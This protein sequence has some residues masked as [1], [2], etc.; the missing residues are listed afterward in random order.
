[1]LLP[2]T[3]SVPAITLWCVSLAWSGA[4]LGVGGIWNP[5]SRSA[6]IRWRGFHLGL[7]FEL[8]AAAVVLL[9]GVLLMATWQLHVK[10]NRTPKH[11]CIGC[12]YKEVR[13]V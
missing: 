10:R 5:A 4:T 2:C 6:I 8:L 12:G 7:M 9:I 1:M 13:I 3:R 11:R